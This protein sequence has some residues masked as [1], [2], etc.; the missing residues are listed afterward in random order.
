MLYTDGYRPSGGGGGDVCLHGQPGSEDEDGHTR[1]IVYCY[2]YI[3]IHLYFI[4]LQA[5]CNVVNYM[6]DITKMSNAHIRISKWCTVHVVTT[7]YFIFLYKH[8]FFIRKTVF[9]GRGCHTNDYT[10]FGYM[11]G[12][13]MSKIKDFL[14]QD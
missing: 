3:I 8:N 12:N 7:I 2:T 4:L 9:G 5:Y 13:I 14:V 6:V 11:H 10:S 1:I